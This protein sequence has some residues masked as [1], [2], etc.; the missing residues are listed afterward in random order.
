MENFDEKLSKEEVEELKDEIKARL[1]SND[2]EE[3]EEELTSEEIA[4]DIKH[5]NTEEEL[6][7]YLE[8]VHNV[9]I[10]ESFEEIESDEELLRVFNLLSDENKAEILEEADEDL[11]KR[12]LYLIPEDEVLEIFSYMSPDDIADILGYIGFTKSKSLLNQM[13]RSE[14]NKLRELLGYADDSAGGIMTTQYIAFKKNLNIKEVMEKIKLIAPRTEYIETIF[15]LDLDGTVIGEA[16]L[17]DILIA[18]ENTLL[19]DITNENILSVRPNDDQEEVA[20]LVSRYGLKVVPVINKRKNLLGIITIDDVVDVIQEEN[21]EDILK[22]AGAGDDESLSTNLS[23]S[24]KKRLPWLL[25]NLVT[26]F[27]ASF[28]VGL[29]SKTIDTVVALAVAMPIVSGMGGNAGTQ[30]LAVT[31]RSIA[32]GEYYEDENFEV[33]IR[34]VFLGFLNGIVLGIICGI[35]IYFMFGNKYL[36]LIIFLSMIGNCI[37]A[38]LVGYLIPIGLKA[39][40]VDPAMA[41]AVLLTTITDVCGFFLFLGLATIYLHKLI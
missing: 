38:S 36:S 33:S 13:K 25:I 4:E 24:M 7:E 30:S 15:V 20:R 5:L 19:E 41:S 3:E 21:T 23:E 28:T 39:I 8:E 17:R 40:K 29:F 18:D 16:D 9:D 6:T 22:L 35:I 11:Q 32:L 12:I 27:L 26:A 31:I 2:E 10:A 1:S 14:A 34:Y 37:I